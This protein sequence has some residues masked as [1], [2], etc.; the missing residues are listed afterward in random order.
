[1]RSIVLSMAPDDVEAVLDIVLPMA[2]LGVHM[3]ERGGESELILYGENAALFDR[4]A[5][6][7]RCGRLVR[8]VEAGEAPRRLI[9][10]G[11]TPADA[12]EVVAGY[13]AIG[14]RPEQCWNAAEWTVVTLAADR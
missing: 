11:V 9:A 1:M 3:R 13:A 7:D 12:E 2:P 8:C 6:A 4:D 5:V 10:T 14:L